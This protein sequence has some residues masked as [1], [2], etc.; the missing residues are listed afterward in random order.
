[1][2]RGLDKDRRFGLVQTHQIQDTKM[3]VKIDVSLSLELINQT[4]IPCLFP[5]H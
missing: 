3:R 5:P 4:R 2:H 1:M